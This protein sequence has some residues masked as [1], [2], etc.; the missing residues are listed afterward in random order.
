MSQSI[1]IFDF[2]RTLYDPETGGLIP[3]ANM[4]LEK[5]Q[6]SEVGLLLVTQKEGQRAELFLKLQIIHFFKHIHLVNDKQAAFRLIK[7]QYKNHELW[8]VGDRVRG[9]IRYGNELDMVTVWYKQGHFAGEVPAHP[10]ETPDFTV[11]DLSEVAPLIL[12]C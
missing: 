11:T 10:A 8:V 4:L 6:Q 7:Q 12:Q 3:G 2:M 1:I 9:E 5:L